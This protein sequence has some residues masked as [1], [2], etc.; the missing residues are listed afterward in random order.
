MFPLSGWLMMA[1]FPLLSMSLAGALNYAA[2]AAV[3]N[4]AVVGELM[5][6]VFDG[7]KARV[8]ARRT[9]TQANRNIT[10]LNDC[11]FG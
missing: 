11:M 6:H 2:S 3:E 7:E 1:K 4:R 8:C 9:A 10:I 5:F